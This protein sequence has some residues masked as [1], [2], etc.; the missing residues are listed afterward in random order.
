MN[1]QLHHRPATCNAQARTAEK[2]ARSRRQGSRYMPVYAANP[3]CCSTRGSAARTEQW[4]PEDEDAV[5]FGVTGWRVLAKHKG[6][7]LQ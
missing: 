6:S 2:R 5:A 3:S 1:L 7:L 4:A